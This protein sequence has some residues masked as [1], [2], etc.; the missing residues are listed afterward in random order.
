MKTFVLAFII[1]LA[2]VTTPSA[3]GALRGPA[4]KE[5]RSDAQETSF[6]GRTHHRVLV[7]GPNAIPSFVQG[8]LG[9]IAGIRNLKDLDIQA[10]AQEILQSL[11]KGKNFGAIGSVGFTSKGKTFT[12]KD[13]SI[14][15]RFTQSIGGRS[16]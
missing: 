12:T 4:E 13:G 10:K 14:H 9:R 16:V 2:A 1:I 3:H 15:L 6:A 8:N 5:S 7:T 11:V